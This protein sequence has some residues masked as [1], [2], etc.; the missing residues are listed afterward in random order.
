MAVTPEET[1]PDTEE[2]DPLERKRWSRTSTAAW[3][4]YQRT[5]AVFTA[6]G[7]AALLGHLWPIR[8][9]GALA[10]I[11]GIWDAT[12][13]PAMEWVLHVLVTVPLSWRGVDLEVPLRV[14]DYLAVGV[15]V[16]SSLIGDRRVRGDASIG[17]AFVGRWYLAVLTVAAWPAALLAILFYLPVRRVNASLRI[18]RTDLGLIFGLAA[19][20]VRLAA[21]MIFMPFAIRALLSAPDVLPGTEVYLV[22]FLLYAWGGRGFLRIGYLLTRDPALQEAAKS[23]GLVLSPLLY[24]AMLLVL[25]VWVLPYIS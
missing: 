19:P 3:S 6:L 8:W 4:V 10:A 2:P 16:A 1:R 18:R 20:F 11:V 7:I 21:F 23:I 9:R 12:V 17:S 24:L 13:R 25:N 14:R 22:V 15:V 5:A